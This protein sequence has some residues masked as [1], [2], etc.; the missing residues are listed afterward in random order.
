MP[1]VKLLENCA[2]PCLVKMNV[3]GVARFAF[4]GKR[5]NAFFPA[6]V[7]AETG[8]EALNLSSDMGFFMHPYDVA[9]ALDFGNDFHLKPSYAGNCEIDKGDLFRTPGAIVR[10]GDDRDYLVAVGSGWKN[11]FFYSLKTGDFRAE[12]GGPRVAFASWVL[13]TEDD[14]KRPLLEMNVQK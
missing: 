8:W 3:E 13:F 7:L 12:P 4:L 6:F 14:Q 9:S 1:I 10:A 5:G 11:P 2:P